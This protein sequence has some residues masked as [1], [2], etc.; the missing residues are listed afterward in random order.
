MDTY[1]NNTS[2]LATPDTNPSIGLLSQML[3]YWQPGP[4]WDTGTALVPDVLDANIDT[5]IEITRTRTDAGAT[6][7][8]LIDRRNQN[9]S[10]IDGLG[11]YADAFR[12]ASNAG[13]TIPDAIPADATS[14][15]YDDAGNSNG[16]WADAVS[17]VG[18]VVSL[19]NT[20]RGSYATSN[21]AKNY[22][23]YPRPFRWSE[24]VSV[25]PTLEPVKKPVEEAASDNGYPSGHTNAGYLASYA[26][27]YAFP[28]Q[29]ADLLANASDIGNSRIVAGMHSPADV[30]GGR[31]LATAIA[32]AV[33]NDPAYAALLDEA[34][35][36]ALELLAA[37]P[38]TTSTAAVDEEATI[39]RLTYGL[40]RVG[41]TTLPVVVPKG[42]EALLQTRMP[43]LSA[44]QRR[45][46]L[47]ST[48]LESG[49]ALLDDAEGW[50]RL[51]LALAVQGYGAFDTDVVVDMDA[52]DG[53]FSAADA[54][55]NDIDGDGSLTKQGSG[56]LT[57]SGDNTYLGG[58]IVDGGSLVATS[59]TAL[60][61]GS[62][63]AAD[64]LLAE[65]VD[66]TLAITGDYAQ[67]DA[68]ELS[69][70]VEDGSPLAIAG[71]AT[72]GGRLSVA[73]AEGAAPA[74]DVVLATYGSLAASRFTSVDVDSLPA[75]YEPELQYRDGALHLVNAAAEGAEPQPGD[76]GGDD[77]EPGTGTPG[78]GEPGNG[79]GGNDAGEGSDD[80]T[81]SGDAEAGDDLAVTGATDPSV[82]IL[83][84]GT[85]LV[86]G[87]V[88][89]LIARRRRSGDV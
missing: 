82:L 62:V 74:D 45:W 76:G 72:F 29:Y 44:D 7:A 18:S 4:T 3:E 8:Y 50:G 60:G 37:Q 73:F 88:V 9:Y 58:T 46:V 14:V 36:E 59:A 67:S 47:Q 81:G 15:K 28:E 22:Y 77:G 32:A 34:R 6:D 19:V 57:L 40:P 52:A 41:D 84:A 89:L 55:I 48:G 25:L 24:D 85:L 61:D 83:G 42:A 66:G 78:E 5:S 64:G 68:G 79:D 10:A 43:Y 20:I 17:E 38:T 69:L 26:L 39:A 70:T 16:T 11:P 65:T 27:A 33:L 63:A 35:T 56:V 2:A 31:I 13:T 86:A 80:G 23:G 54:W 49:Y 51:N 75:G 12:S 1:L 21:N 71:E 53:G 30:I 87:A